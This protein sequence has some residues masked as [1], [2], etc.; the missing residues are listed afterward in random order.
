MASSL[1][2]L[3]RG[4]VSFT[5]SSDVDRGAATRRKDLP[6]DQTLANGTGSN[7]A[8]KAFTDQ[9]S[10]SASGSEELDLAGGLTTNG[11]TLTFVKVKAIVIEAAAANGGNIVV[12]GAS[13]NAFQGPFGDASD[14]LEIPAGGKVALFAPVGGWA[15]TAGTGDL[16]QIAN[17]DSGSAASYEIDIIGT[18]A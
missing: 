16:L 17:D 14:T 11:E 3:L 7:Q 9:R 5:Y 1:T 4:G 13:S 8:D 2:A 6:G 15:V 10:L 12:G 18:S